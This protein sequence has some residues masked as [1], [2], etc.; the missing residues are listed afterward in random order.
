M[1]RAVFLGLAVLGVVLGACASPDRRYWGSDPVEQVIEGWRYT[2][3]TRPNRRSANRPYVQVI[4]LGYAR[5][6]EH[7]AILAAM[8]QAAV[9]ATGCPL[10]EGSVQGDSGVMEARL[11][12]AG[13]TP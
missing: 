12:C 1:R 4:R 9:Q 13:R 7:V 10:V 11:D 8:Q 6:S 5:R 2:V 3:Y